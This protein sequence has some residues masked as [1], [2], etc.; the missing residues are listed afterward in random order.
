M[1][2]VSKKLKDECDKTE[3][4][5]ATTTTTTTSSSESKPSE[6]IYLPDPS[7]FRPE[8]KAKNE[9]RVYDESN[10]RFPIV[11]ATYKDMHE[12]MTVDFVTKKR[13]QW[14]K[15]NKAKMNIMDALT[16]LNKLVDESD[17]DVD[18][19]NSIHAFQTA[20]RIRQCHP[21]LDWMHLTGLIHDLGKVIAVWGES[22]WCTVGD[23]Y[24]VGAAPAPSCVFVEQFENCV[25]QQDPRYNTQLGMY[26]ANCGLDKVTMSFGHDEYMYQLLKHNKCTLPDEAMYMIRYHSFYPWHTGGDYRHFT[27]EVDEKM[28]PWVLEFNKFD[29]YS[30]SD[31]LPD[32]KALTPYYQSLIDKY[33][34][35]VLSW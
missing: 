19:P 2:Q 9:F 34:P 17:P 35:G 8:K 10:A 11:R 21:D 14:F 31:D 30:K 27:N 3:S 4:I 16:E 1:E 33:C 6:V 13:E 32:A 29:L 25:D 20:E 24:V 28:L 12:N 15:F 7:E 26:Q 23:T 5:T 22:Q 18:V